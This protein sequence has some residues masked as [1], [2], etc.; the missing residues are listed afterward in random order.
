MNLVTRFLM[1][2]ALVAIPLSAWAA[3]LQTGTNRTRDINGAQVDKWRGV[4]GVR[5]DLA[6]G[7]IVLVMPNDE[8]ALNH[9]PDGMEFLSD[10]RS[11]R[12]GVTAQVTESGWT[13]D[14][15]VADMV[16]KLKTAHGGTWTEPAAVNMAGIP[17]TTASGYDVFGNY[18]FEIYAVER[19][20]MQYLVW[21]R[22]PYQN[23]WNTD[24][25]ADVAW[26]INNL[27]P[28]TRTVMQKLE[29]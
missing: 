8:W 28:S 16:A 29:K 24:L 11:A 17:A 21:M 19:L 13:P 27:H 26:V 23:R 6:K 20:G 18:Y 22:T 3:D 5:Y 9:V 2:L 10:R 1:A 15:A 14:G 25:N 4:K 12:M 7:M